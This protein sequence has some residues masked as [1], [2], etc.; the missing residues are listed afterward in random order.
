MVSTTEDQG[1]AEDQA[2]ASSSTRVVPEDQAAASSS[3][4]VVP[5][6]K[7]APTQAQLDEWANLSSEEKRHLMREAWKTMQGKNMQ[8]D[9]DKGRVE[10]APAED[11]EPRSARRTLPGGVAALKIK[12]F[13]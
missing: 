1:E 8:E 11:V 10:G 3:T 13:N 2:A 5:S 9:E 7:A 12:K 6:A 4:R